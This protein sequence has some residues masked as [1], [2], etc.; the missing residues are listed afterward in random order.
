ERTRFHPHGRHGRL[1]RPLDRWPRRRRPERPQRRRVQPGHRPHHR[2]GGAGK[3]G[4]SRPRSGQRAGRFPGLGRHAADPPRAGDVQV[5]R[6]AEPAPRRTGACHHRRTRQGLQRCARRSDARHRHRGVRLWHSAAAQGPVHRPGL[7]R[8][9]QLDDAPAPGRG[10]GHHAVQL[11]GDGSDVD[12]PGGHR[13]RQQL[14]AQ[15]QSAG[16]VGLDPDGAPAEGSRPARRRLQRRAGRQGRRRCVAGAPGCEGD[17]VRRLDTDRTEDLRDRRPARQAG[18]GAGWRQEPHGGDAGRRPGP[19]GGRA[20]RFGVRVGRRALHGD[21][22]GGAGGR[23]GRQDH[24][25]AGGAHAAAEDQERHRSR[26]RD[27]SDREQCRAAAHRRLHRRRRAGGRQA[28]GGWPRLPGRQGRRGLRQRLLDRRHAIRPRDARDEDLQG[29]DLRPGARLRAGQG[30]GR[31]RG[32]DQL[33]RVRQR[34]LLLHARRQRGARVLAPGAGGDGGHQ[35]ADP[36]ADGL[37]W[38]WRLEEE[39]VRR[40]ACLRRGRRALLH[41]A[42]IDHAALA[43]EHRQG[44][45]VRDPDGEM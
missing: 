42:E 17:L 19:G 8:H 40:H 9:R 22:A 29:G 12:V 4:R 10:G 14:R 41:Q 27:G 1:D 18:A 37:A 43:G 2:Q 28:G 25:D 15:A 6:A 5:P 31:R 16:P 13:R 23:G 24:A 44:S 36:G 11:S 35:R 30:P 33:A 26:R 21:F 34:R 20:D 32:A 7:H 39:P 45:G 38:L 3:L